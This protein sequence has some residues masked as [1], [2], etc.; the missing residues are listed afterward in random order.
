MRNR[1]RFGKF[2]FAGEKV[3]TR[4]ALAK[5]LAGAEYLPSSGMADAGPEAGDRHW[6]FWPSRP[7]ALSLSRLALSPNVC[8]CFLPFPSRGNMAGIVETWRHIES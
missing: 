1:N 2:F 4:R 7:R 6:L 5:Q 8:C 3:P